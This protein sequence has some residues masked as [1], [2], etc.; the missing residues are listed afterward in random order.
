V[1]GG[2]ASSVFTDDPVVVLATV[3]TTELAMLPDD[4][5]IVVVPAVTAVALPARSTVATPAALLDHV[6]APGGVTCVLHTLKRSPERYA[7]ELSGENEIPD[8]PGDDT[9]TK[10][11]ETLWMTFS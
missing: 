3:S 7:S 5:E 11:E 10:L 8:M 9:C 1:L 4:A 6:T 2:P